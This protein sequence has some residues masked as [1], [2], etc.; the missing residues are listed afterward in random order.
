ML[1]VWL[2]AVIAIVIIAIGGNKAETGGTGVN[3]MLVGIGRFGTR[4]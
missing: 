2:E 1:L 4:W 3:E